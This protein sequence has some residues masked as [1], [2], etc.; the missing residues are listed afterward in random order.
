MLVFFAG[1]LARLGWGGFE[2]LG[3]N[4]RLAKSCMDTDHFEL[5]L[6]FFPGL[7][8]PARNSHFRRSTKILV[9]GASTHFDQC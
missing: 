3:K 5:L 9:K 4:V 7:S 2:N 1:W 6:E 8:V